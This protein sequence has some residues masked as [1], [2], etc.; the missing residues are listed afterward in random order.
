MWKTRFVLCMLVVATLGIMAGAQPVIPRGDIV[1]TSGYWQRPGIWNP[2]GWS[3]AWGA[4]FMYEPLF[5]VNWVT[6]EVQGII[7]ES[8][9]WVDPLTIEIVIRPEATWTDGKPITADDVIYTY[10]HLLVNH[11][12]VGG[13]AERRAEIIAV[14]P[15]VVQVKLHPEYAH[16]LVVWETLTG[17]WLIVP[18]H[19]WVEIEKEVGGFPYEWV[20]A[21]DWAK[22]K[23]EWRVASGMYLPLDW[24]WTAERLV[25][26]DNWWGKAVWGLPAPKY[27]GQRY[28][29][30]NFAA[31][32]AFE[33]G[34]IDWYSSYYPRMWELATK[35]MGAFISTWT[36]RKP[37]FFRHS[38][39]VNL[40]FNH[41][42]YPLNEPWLRH[43]IAHAINYQDIA[44][45]A[46]SGYTELG[47]VTHL[48][49]QNP[50]HAR[51]IDPAVLARYQFAY[52][53]EKAIA[54]LE[55]HCI[56]H[57][58]VWYTK[59][60]PETW[61]GT[62]ITD[63]LPDTPGRNVRL[64]PWKNMA[65]HGWT[66]SMMQNVLLQR[67]LGDIGIRV[68]PVFLEYAVYVDKF[69]AMDFDLMNF[70]MGPT[71]AVNSL[72]E[73]YATMFTGTPG[74]WANY[75]AYDHP[76]YPELA[77][78]LSD[79]LAQLDITP[80]GTPEEKAIAARLQEI[81]ARDLPMIPM[82]FNGYWYAFSQQYWHNWPSAENPYVFPVATWAI[83]DPGAMQIILRSL[84]KG[85]QPLPVRDLP[86]VR[87]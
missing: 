9:R 69:T 56:R 25:R 66:D 17:Q 80:R 39:T 18:K 71:P 79:L 72:W 23:P 47:T 37:P 45:T 12:R 6:G 44:M 68:E 82:W 16:S 81:I 11:W 57:A 58:G 19:V 20:F 32:S 74:Q 15:K 62:P 7:G 33:A 31:N 64:G 36:H 41:N 38:A 29:E 8:I 60:A 2:L 1:W 55:Q 27:I 22:I 53:P 10:D 3:T 73:Y 48:T 84:V 5:Q 86:W 30:T 52:D 42:I 83:G 67:D 54:I 50:E 13:Y 43:A 4:F 46:A 14:S 59:D 65:V 26:N 61:R 35:P 77:Q 28:F 76:E 87:P 40:V 70:T 49:P 75:A 51:I 24:S 34:E 21:N 78:E 63:M 85:P